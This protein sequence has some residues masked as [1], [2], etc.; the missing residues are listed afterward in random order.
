M[1]HEVNLRR[2]AI[3]ARISSDPEHNELGV[4]RQRADCLALCEREQFEVVEVLTDD[5]RSAYSGK[6]RPGYERL[7]ELLRDRL[8]DVVVA[9]HPDRLTRHPRELEELIEALEAAQ[10]TVRTVTAGELDLSTPAGRMTAR[11]VGAVARHES[12]HKSQRVRRKHLELAEAGKVSGGGPRPF[13]F[14]TDRVTVRPDEAAEIRDAVARLI[15]GESLRSVAM[16]MNRRGVAS[17]KGAKWRSTTLRRVVVSPR[18]A[19][20]REHKSG[21]YPAVWEP[22]ISMEDHRRVMAVLN[23]RKPV[24][25]PAR[26]Y[27]LS[28]FV[29]C[30]LCGARMV[31]RPRKNKQRGYVCATGTNFEGCGRISVMAEPVEALVVAAVL[32][33]LA[34]FDANAEPEPSPATDALAQLVEIERRQAELGAM[35][36]AGDIDAAVVKAGSR[37]LDEQRRTLEAEVARQG[38]LE[39]SRKAVDVA[40]ASRWPS[41]TFEQ[42]RAVIGQVVDHVVIR[43]GV[44]GYNFVDAKRVA[45]VW[46]A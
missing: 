40:M 10:A 18:I 5:D 38:R 15:A 23:E 13:G 20:L 32:E 22:I 4:T 12:E 46:R 9:W 34:G 30:D 41:L 2:A 29:R 44:R 3:Y 24:T 45:I 31:A 1:L 43:R 6:R 19:G 16:D 17:G 42:Q 33:A 21:L 28:G 35:F 8:V 7:R 14:D 11:V 27:L 25:A 37:A 36:A 26:R 39:G